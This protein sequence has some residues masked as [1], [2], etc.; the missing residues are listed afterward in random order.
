MLL[1]NF[2]NH[3]ADSGLPM[4]HMLM[5]HDTSGA[6]TGAYV[7]ECSPLSYTGGG[8]GTPTTREHRRHERRKSPAA[9]ALAH[10]LMG[11]HR[12][13]GAGGVSGVRRPIACG[14]GVGAGAGANMRGAG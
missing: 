10:R 7:Q 6:E 3:T 12:E 11:R 8:G 13:V 14:Q 4:Q 1:T 2:S 9:K 5:D